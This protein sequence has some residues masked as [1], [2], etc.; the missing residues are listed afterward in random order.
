MIG[1]QVQ[2][3]SML[4]P[5][6]FVPV[7]VAPTF[8]N[9]N[10]LIDIV[11]RVVVQGVPLIVV[12]DGSTDATAELLAKWKSSHPDVAMKIITH[13]R[14]RGK[15]AA[16]RSGFAAAV[17]SGYTHAATIDT[18]GQLDPE[19]IPSLL[20]VARK[21]PH[22]LVVGARDELAPDYPG[23]SRLGRRLSN[24]MIFL[25]SGARVRDSQCGLRVYP[26]GLV[27]AT[28]CR[29]NYFGFET[30]IITRAGWAGCEIIDVAVNCRYLPPGQRVSHFRPWLDTLRVL[31]LH[32]RLLGRTLWPLSRHP[33]WPLRLAMPHRTHGQRLR[34]LAQ[35]LSPAGALRQ[36]RSDPGS[37]TLLATGLALGAFIANLPVYGLQTVLSIYA[38]RRL[39]LH[40]LSVVLGSQLSVPPVGPL[41]IAAAIGV[42][43]LLLHGSWPVLA[44]FKPGVD[45]VVHLVRSLMLEWIIGGV[46]L[47]IISG[48]LTF[49]IA[50]IVFR[51][52]D[53][54]AMSLAAGAETPSV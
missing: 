26:L 38:A 32:A 48:I 5:A 31:R 47:G 25:E 52:G 9:C 16:L 4:E 24:L 20:S 40:P 21:S 22:S 3:T 36:W 11:S 45:G 15:A 8:N 30:E 44:D 28:Q 7:V 13:A 10:T 17:E 50:S 29:A 34:A 33:Q 51:A 54:T 46:L 49:V 6:R 1:D 18:D 12:N 43:H 41:L 35:W 42:G 14:N 2:S 53:A 37:R 19:Q 27:Q 23:R 39:H